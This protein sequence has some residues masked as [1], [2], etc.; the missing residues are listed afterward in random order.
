MGLAS[1][2][3]RKL[4]RASFTGG[5]AMPAPDAETLIRALKERLRDVE[6]AEVRPSSYR[7]GDHPSLCDVSLRDP[8]HTWRS[9][10]DLSLH[11][12]PAGTLVASPGYWLRE[13]HSPVASLDE[14]V[15]LVHAMQEAL[16]RRHA[17]KQRSEKVRGFKAQAVLATVRKLAE[18]ESLQY[19]AGMDT[20]KL[21]LHVA[22]GG[23]DLLELHIPFSQ[24]EQVLP[25]LRRTILSL[26][27]LRGSGIRFRLRTRAALRA[28]D[29]QWT[30]APEAR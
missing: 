10:A 26:K 6:G 3:T 1:P 5:V 16:A 17:Q 18:E 20:Q 4:F 22:V 30:N 2:T 29:Y 12:T 19:W 28:R 9:H 7:A 25:E 15:A 11:R 14:V 27:E 13:D 24:L 21:L 23:D 8:V